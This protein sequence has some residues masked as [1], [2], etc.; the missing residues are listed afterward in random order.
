MAIPLPFHIYIHFSLAL[1]AGYLCGRYFRRPVLCLLVAFIAGFLIDLDHV[2]EYFLVFGPHFDLAGFFAG[3]Q[4]L[5]S[6]KIYLWFHAWEWA[7]LFFAL[8]W[9]SRKRSVGRAILITAALAGSVHLL[10]DNLINNYPLRFYS[11]SY[12]Y[13]QDFSAPRL[14]SPEQYRRNMLEKEGLG[15]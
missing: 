9:L 1:V 11:L 4:F 13:Q 3:R 6:D 5:T 2:L 8:G 10:S 15:G 14:L 12:R 7:I